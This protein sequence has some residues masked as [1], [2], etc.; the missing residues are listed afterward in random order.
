MSFVCNINNLIKVK[1]F[2]LHI[3]VI[4]YEFPSPKNFLK[5]LNI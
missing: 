1:L 4:P 5:S 3:L 2:I